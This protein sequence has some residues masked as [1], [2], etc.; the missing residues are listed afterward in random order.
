M[1]VLGGLVVTVLAIRPKIRGFKLGEGKKNPQQ[2]FL[3]RGI[4]AVGPM[5]K[6][7]VEC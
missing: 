4:K 7:L 1:V 6:D 3:R 2:N 5:L